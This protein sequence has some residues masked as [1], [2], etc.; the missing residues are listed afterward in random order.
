MSRAQGSSDGGRS[1]AA[2][3][4]AI[5]FGFPLRERSAPHALVDLEP[6][7]F[8]AERRADVADVRRLLRDYCERE[9]EAGGK[10]VAIVPLSGGLDSRLVLATLLELLPARDI[11]CYTYGFEG[12]LDYQIAPIV[13]RK[14]GV[15]HVVRGFHEI[16]FDLDELEAS[17]KGLDVESTPTLNLIA[18]YYTKKLSALCLAELPS[19]AALW[20]GFL[21]DRVWAGKWLAE[22]PLGLRDSVANYVGSYAHPIKTQLLQGNY[23]PL[24]RLLAIYEGTRHPPGSSWCEWIDLLQRQYHVKRS[25]VDGERKYVFPLA[26]PDVVKSLLSMPISQRQQYRFYRRYALGGHAKLFG[27]PTTTRFGAPLRGSQLREQVDRGLR[28]ARQRIERALHVRLGRF[29]ARRYDTALVDSTWPEHRV[30]IRRGLESTS[31]RL[32]ELGSTNAV[33]FEAVIGD[34]AASQVLASLGYVL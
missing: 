18:H 11:Y 23:D 34:R 14:A 19:D 16:A 17:V 7:S 29:E 2:I 6:T 31:R 26:A 9:L 32:A 21:G 15:S 1:V 13:A 4:D 27:C 8:E 5:W 22:P 24:Q 20:S 25:F 30:A 3:G 28:L 10:R 33:D 12:H